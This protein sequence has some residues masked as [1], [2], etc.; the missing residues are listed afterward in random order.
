MEETN[1]NTCETCQALNS[2]VENWKIKLMSS[3]VY[4]T[5]EQSVTDLLYLGFQNDIQMNDK[6]SCCQDIARAISIV[7]QSS[8]VSRG[9][10]ICITEINGTLKLRLE[11]PDKDSDMWCNLY[12]S[13]PSHPSMRVARNIQPH[14]D[15]ALFRRWLRCC[16][17]SHGATCE[18][19][20]L[21]APSVTMYLVDTTQSCIVHAPRGVRYI[22]L[23]YVWGGVDVTKTTKDNI[24]LMMKPGIFDNNS[25]DFHIPKTISDAIQLVSLLG[26]R[27]LWVDSLCIIQDQQH[28]KQSALESM[29]SIYANAYLTIVAAAGSDANYGLCG[30][31]L[32]TKSRQASCETIKLR[33]GMRLLVT[34][35]NAWS[36]EDS[37][38]NLRAWTFQ[39]GLL[40]RRLLIFNE[41]ISWICRSAT[42]QEFADCP[43]EDLRYAA[44]HAPQDLSTHLAIKIP[45]WPDL[46]YWL[47]LVNMYCQRNLTH[48]SDA[49]SAFAGTTTVFN[50][51]FAGGILWGIPEMFF[52]YCLIWLPRSLLHRRHIANPK[53]SGGF[54]SWSWYG[55]EG[56]IVVP[57]EEFPQ[58]YRKQVR[59]QP[60]V[61]FFKIDPLTTRR[62]ALSNI[63]PELLK[64]YSSKI[65]KPPPLGWT[66]YSLM[67]GFHFFE[68]ELHPKIRF[69]CPL[70]LSN[71]D[72]IVSTF[73][74][75]TQLYFRAKRAS[76]FIGSALKVL[77]PL[78]SWSTIAVA[79]ID[80]SGYV[81]GATRLN[82]DQSSELPTGEKCELIALSY[83]EAGSD[84]TETMFEEGAAAN[85]P[86]ENGMYCFYNVMWIQWE[87]G[88]AYRKS[89]GRV[90]KH[91]WDEQEL[92]EIDVILG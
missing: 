33:H 22:A 41:T 10:M 64:E 8:Q 76:F 32:I 38:W 6:C 79:L 30:M 86:R 62:I 44:F 89:V 68:H 60:V 56:D 35:S 13:I 2:I 52:D 51:V 78:R 77:V 72:K 59:Y 55:W 66:R 80:D 43:T 74:Q 63:Y 3:H 39:E 67:N 84:R 48:Q 85:L 4:P 27:Y 26:E 31:E 81:V 17:E 50:N 90:F 21:I 65:T 53:S 91:V 61:K 12:P 24:F 49:V 19:S 70:P 1:L 16:D 25:D 20:G 36:P 54:P 15:L 40:S 75:P 45:T 9:S 29:A 73:N 57:S 28:T 14:T 23:S 87:D 42:W 11:M 37:P 7:V 71:E 5:P 82:V 47:E 83:C 69:A 46:S 34:P 92:D 58:I 18:S 88:I